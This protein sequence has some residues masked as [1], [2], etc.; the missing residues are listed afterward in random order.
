MVN[1]AETE[2]LV[3]F[4]AGM[5]DT[6]NYYAVTLNANGNK[7][8]DIL[9]VN[10]TGKVSV[11]TESNGSG[12]I[13]PA[14]WHKIR[15]KRDIISRSLQFYLD[16]MK[17]PA[18]QTN[19]KRLVMGYIGFGSANSALAIDNIKIWSQTSIPQ[20]PGFLRLNK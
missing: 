20:R 11:A 2:G 6:L 1:P 19:N 3:L 13:T 10:G 8:S 4:V 7:P 14:T 5:K 15:I 18:V 16:D 17:T 9:L 12:K